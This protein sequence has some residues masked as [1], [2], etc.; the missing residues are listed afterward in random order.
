MNYRKRD[1]RMHL[2]LV[3]QLLCSSPPEPAERVGVRPVHHF[4]ITS[5]Q[6][7]HLHSVLCQE[8]WRRIAATQ[9][10]HFNSLLRSG[11]RHGSQDVQ[12]YK[13]F[14]SPELVS[15]YHLHSP[16]CCIIA[17]LLTLSHSIT[18]L[19]YSRFLVCFM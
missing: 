6:P 16:T 13:P 17:L 8:G 4:L 3:W 1:V 11:R 12:P 7:V 9:A 18:P 19:L 15:L 14:L 10:T 2:G 5:F